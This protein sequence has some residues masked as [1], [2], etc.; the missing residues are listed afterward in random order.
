[1]VLLATSPGPGGAGTV[2]A[3]ATKSAAY[4]AGD[5]K[6]SVSIPNFYDNFDSEHQALTNPELHDK[7]QTAL[8]LLNE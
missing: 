6:A 1:M 2:L 8:S 3:V 4:F 7:L 5:V